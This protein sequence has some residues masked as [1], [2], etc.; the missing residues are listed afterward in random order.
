VLTNANSSAT[1]SHNINI[2]AVGN[3][4]SGFVAGASSK[5]AYRYQYDPNASTSTAGN[6]KTFTT[7]ADLRYAME[8]EANADG[9]G[10]TSNITIKVNDQGKFEIT[11]PGGSANDYNIGLNITALTTDPGGA[12]VT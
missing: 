4:N 2:N 6:D 7:M 1:A 11:N 5:T 10:A 12:T 8:K 9:G 3:T